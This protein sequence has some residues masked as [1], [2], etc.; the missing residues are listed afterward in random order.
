[1]V[2]E[3]R[4]KFYCCGF[5]FATDEVVEAVTVTVTAAATPATGHSP[6]CS[7]AVCALTSIPGSGLY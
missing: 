1:M 2:R 3:G 6:S 4:K 7:H 5:C